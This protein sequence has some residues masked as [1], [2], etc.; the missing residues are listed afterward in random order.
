MGMVV[1]LVS[2]TPGG[3]QGDIRHHAPVHELPLAE[4]A[5]ELQPL[6]GVQLAG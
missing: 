4:V 6:R 1:A 5:D 2:L 3:V